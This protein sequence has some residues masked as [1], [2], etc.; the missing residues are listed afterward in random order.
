MIFRTLDADGDWTFGKGKSGFLTD[1]DAMVTN[2]KTRT[3]MWKGECFFALQE[4]VDWNNYLDIGTKNL[5][6]S[7]LMRVWMQSDGVI[8]IDSYDST[9]NTETRQL[10]VQASLAT[11]YG[12]VTLSEVL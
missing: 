11:I 12:S 2:L 3:K 6:D 8:R 9:L 4:G 1:K 7:D 10:T 5:L